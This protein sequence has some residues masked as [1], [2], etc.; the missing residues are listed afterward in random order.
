M[1]LTAKSITVD[2]VH[3]TTPADAVRDLQ[4]LQAERRR[5]LHD[6]GNPL[7]QVAVLLDSWVQRNFKTQGGN[8]G[9]WVG[10]K[11]GGRVLP[12]GTIDTSAKLLQDTGLL[13]ASFAPSSNDKIARIGT[14]LPYAAT[15]EFGRGAIPARRML[16]KRADVIEQVKRIFKFHTDK[17]LR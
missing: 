9:G 13:R 7:A 15:H 17:A 11:Y 4:R 16:P 1:E 6:L 10:F 5:K 8:V 12:D 2:G 3:S 14:E